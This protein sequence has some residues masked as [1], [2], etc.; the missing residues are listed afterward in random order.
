MTDSVISTQA[1]GKQYG[2]HVALRDF[3]VEVPPGQVIGILGRNG[4]GKSTLLDLLLGFALP[5]A[6]SS[7][8]WGAD[9]AALPAALKA[10]IGFVPQQD[11]LVAMLTGAQQLALTASFHAGWDA[12]L[13]QRLA[14]DW[15]L[16]LERR[17]SQLSGGERQKLST[18]L[19]LGHAP[20]L[21]VLDEPAASL[22][23]VAR[24]Q[25]MHEILAIAAQGQRTVLYASHIVADIERVANRLWILRDGQLAWQGEVDVLKESVVRL[26]LRGS[27]ELP[28]TFVLP[29]QLSIQRYGNAARVTV[30]G[31]DAAQSAALAAQWAVQVEVE[32]LGLED[33]FLAMHA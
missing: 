25:F 12:A 7:R 17:I 1:L 26:H 22:D 8:V 18:L 21:L 5:T 4:A 24:R 29:G 31:W 9:S 23:P 20:D 16:P 2:R 32:P 13:V 14:G 10:R 30:S 19:A 11:E 28:A 33:I 27:G 3:T 15:L 6:G